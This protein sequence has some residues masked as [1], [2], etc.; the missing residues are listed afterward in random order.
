MIRSASA[1]WQGGLKDGSGKLSTQ[2]GVFKD[3]PIRSTPVS[4]KRPVPTRKSSLPRYRAGGR[5]GRPTQSFARSRAAK[6][7]IRNSF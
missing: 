3:Q 7:G 5:W 2:S 6:A 4:A 1:V